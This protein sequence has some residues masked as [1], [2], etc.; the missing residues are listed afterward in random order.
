MPKVIIF[1]V[2]ETLLDLSP[3][4]ETVGKALNGNQALLTLWFSTLLHYS[5]VSTVS[6]RFAHFG[7]IGVA[8][9]QMVAHSNGITMSKEDAHK[10]II[11]ALLNLPAHPDVKPALAT[12]KQQGF[13][14]ACLTNSSTQGVKTQLEYA[15][16]TKYFDARLSIEPLQIYKPDQRAYAWALE[17][18]NV[19]P[20]EALMVAAHGWD[21][22]GASAAG[23]QTAFVARPGQSLYPLANAPDFNVNDIAQ[24]ADELDHVVR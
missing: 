2:N 23:M 22:A 14:L 15:G 10:A 24:L 18:L 11:P 5:L 6:G 3:M 21:I 9:L 7:A 16:L 20:A 17:Q 8:A 1:D 19:K 13:T 12:L 4:R